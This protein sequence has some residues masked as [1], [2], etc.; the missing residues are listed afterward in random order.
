MIELLHGVIEDVVEVRI[1][2]GVVELGRCPERPI[3]WLPPSRTVHHIH[4]A[5]SVHVE[6]VISEEVEWGHGG[7]ILVGASH[8]HISQS[9][10]PSF[11]SGDRARKRILIMGTHTSRPTLMPCP[12]QKQSEHLP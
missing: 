7:A 2:A 11:R 6:L 10:P 4:I 8:L 3:Q 1:R 9:L 12:Y 5:P